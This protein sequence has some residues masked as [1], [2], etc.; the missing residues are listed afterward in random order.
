M[1][2]QCGP[3]RRGTAVE[4]VQAMRATP[5]FQRKM[6][7]ARRDR[8]SLHARGSVSRA[9][10][11]NAGRSHPASRCA[12]RRKE[13]RPQSRTSSAMLM[14]S[15]LRGNDVARGTNSCVPS[16]LYSRGETR[17]E[18]VRKYRRCRGTIRVVFVLPEMRRRRCSSMC[19]HEAES[20]V[21]LKAM[22]RRQQVS[23]AFCQEACVRPKQ[24][25]K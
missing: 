21:A 22:N 10:A 13:S 24:D 18:A 19:Y 2:S 11:F 1:C 5:A 17:H 12:R 6:A 23:A 9:M 3:S 20:R 14:E 7:R 15:V 8:Q 4:M 16:R 25:M